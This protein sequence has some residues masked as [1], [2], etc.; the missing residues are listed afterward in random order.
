MSLAALRGGAS[1]SVT[2]IAGIIEALI[3]SRMAAIPLLKSER[4]VLRP[5]DRDPAQFG[6]LVDHGVAAETAIAAGLGAAERHLRLVSDGR[7][8]DMADPGLDPA[9]DCHRPLDVLA[10]HR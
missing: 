1:L 7:A 2:E 6:D 9:G 5:L 10:E 3:R 4:I 8:V